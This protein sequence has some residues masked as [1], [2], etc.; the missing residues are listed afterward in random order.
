MIEKEKVDFDK[1]DTLAANVAE[2]KSSLGV[3]VGQMTLMVE[4]LKSVGGGRARG[5]GGGRRGGVDK[6]YDGYQLH[7]FVVS[8]SV[9]MENGLDDL[10][11]ALLDV[12]GDDVK[13]PQ[14]NAFAKAIKL[15]AE[16]TQEVILWAPNA[17]YCIV[18]HNRIGESTR[19][20]DEKFIVPMEYLEDLGHCSDKSGVK[21]RIGYVEYIK[22]EKEV[23]HQ[24]KVMD[25][26]NRFSGRL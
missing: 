6:V 24:E 23:E 19:G 2:I 10:A 4:L 3:L 13:F 26:I 17:K 15:H 5:E 18:G 8:L 20:E 21:N 14:D 16:K 7:Y 12:L 11:L 9:L 25:K 1:L 22:A